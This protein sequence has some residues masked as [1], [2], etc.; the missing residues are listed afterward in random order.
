MGALVSNYFHGFEISV[1]FHVFAKKKYTFLG[2]TEY[3]Y[4]YFL[5]LLVCK[6]ARS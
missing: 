5:E 1:K 3:I 2:V 6:F 4:E